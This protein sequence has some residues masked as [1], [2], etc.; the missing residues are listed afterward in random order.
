MKQSGILLHISSLPNS[1]GIGDLGPAAYAFADYLEREGHTIWQILPLNYPG[2]GNSP[3]NPISAFAYNEYLI[4]PELLL[5]DGLLSENELLYLPLNSV[6]DF[7]AVHQAKDLM[8]SLAAKRFLAQNDIQEFVQI[9][10][11]YI[12]PYLC[13]AWLCHKYGNS[14]WYTWDNAHKHYSNEL[15]EYCWNEP[16]VLRAAALQMIFIDQMKRL[17]QYL[18]QKGI[19]LFGDMPLYLSYESAEV[20]ANQHLFDLDGSGA[21]LSVAGVPPDVYACEGQ[22]WGNPTYKWDKLRDEGFSLFS[23]RIGQALDFLDLLRLDHFIGYVN[24]WKV[25]CNNGILPDTAINGAWTKALPQDLFSVLTER[26]GTDR[27]VAEDLGILNEEVCRI[28]DEMGLPGMIILQ[29]CFEESV[30]NVQDYPSDRIIYTGTHDNNTTRGWWDALPID[31]SSRK[32]LQEFCQIHLDGLVPSSENIAEIIMETARRSGCKRMI[33]PMQDILALDEKARM[34]IP[35]T[36]LGN[37]QWRLVTEL[38]EAPTRN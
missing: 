4:S 31:S 26:F 35:G 28:R 15:Y 34:N 19:T 1:F 29:F 10:A 5:Q 36:A 32:H 14:E 13:F 6:V 21:R 25:A 11:G 9:H 33:F 38:S 8:L 7:P 20:W 24:Y 12:K 23:D 16:E 27:L 37:W 18:K 2:Y 17:K 3:Y 30:P 22:L